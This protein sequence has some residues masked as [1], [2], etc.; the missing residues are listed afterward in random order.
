MSLLKSLAFFILGALFGALVGA[1]VAAMLAPQSG[2]ELKLNIQ[3]RKGAAVQARQRAE[4]ETAAALR[5]KFRAKVNDPEALR[6][7]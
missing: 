5:E 6:G 4:I 2:D 1:L 3:N 7:V